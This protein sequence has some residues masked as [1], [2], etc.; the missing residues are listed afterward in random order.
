VLGELAGHDLA[1]LGI[2][3]EATWLGPATPQMRLVV[4]KP[5]LVAPVD[6]PVSAQLAV[7]GL[8]GLAN[9]RRDLLDRLAARASAISIRSSWDR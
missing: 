6:L 7:D 8:V 3:G 1:E 4:R 5:R 9:P 2:H